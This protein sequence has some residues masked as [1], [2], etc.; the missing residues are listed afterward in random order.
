MFNE[1]KQYI[2][3]AETDL[4]TTK[5]L[6]QRLE[7]EMLSSP[8][9]NRM[10]YMP[11]IADYKKRE[12]EYK[13]QISRYQ[14]ELS[15]F[16]AATNVAKINMATAEEELRKAKVNGI[17][18]SNETGNLIK[19]AQSELTVLL[20]ERETLQKIIQEK[21][22]RVAEISH[23]IGDM[24]KD[25]NIAENQLMIAKNQL[26]AAEIENKPLKTAME[27]VKNEQQLVRDKIKSF[28]EK[29]HRLQR[30]RQELLEKLRNNEIQA[31]EV[32]QKLVRAKSELEEVQTTLNNARMVADAADKRH[33]VAESKKAQIT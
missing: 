29:M 27:A 24:L 13:Y 20:N 9:G 3:A 15:N 18:T 25:I 16:S 33:N 26:S 11:R 6:I 21:E 19:A 4:Q 31:V 8:E 23:S 2:N 17:P 12:E 1:K 28:T 14:A 22:G 7:A 5:D 30:D 10:N 32:E